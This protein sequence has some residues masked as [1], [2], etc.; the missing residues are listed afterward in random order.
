MD[1]AYL[2]IVSFNHYATDVEPM[3]LVGGN[4]NSLAASILGL[5]SSGGT[6]IGCGILEAISVG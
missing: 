5:T 6:C 3:T 1:T 4:R 2:G